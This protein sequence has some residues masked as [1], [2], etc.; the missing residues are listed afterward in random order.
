MNW[1]KYLESQFLFSRNILYNLHVN[2]SN[3]VLSALTFDKGQIWLFFW[4]QNLLKFDLKKQLKQLK[5]VWSTLTHCC[6]VQYY[7][8]WRIFNILYT[9]YLQNCSSMVCC[10]L[11]K[12]A[13][14]AHVYLDGLAFIV[15]W[16]WMN[17]SAIH[18]YGACVLTKSTDIGRLGLF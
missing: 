8:V 18:V 14:A 17:A 10:S 9:V 7:T 2:V 11:Y 15:Q 5:A 4:Y 13:L 1:L 6:Q 16:M 12:A 3:R